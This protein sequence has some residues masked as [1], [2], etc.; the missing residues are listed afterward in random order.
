V[1]FR[2][3]VTHESPYVLSCARFFAEKA[4]QC[5]GNERVDFEAFI[6]AAIAFARAAVLRLKSQY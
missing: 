2:S 5:S 4:K 1:L 3:V 6:E